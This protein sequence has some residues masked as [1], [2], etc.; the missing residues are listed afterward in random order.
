MSGHR[1]CGRGG[2][3][4]LLAITAGGCLSLNRLTDLS[5]KFAAQFTLRLPEFAPSCVFSVAVVVRS[6]WAEAKR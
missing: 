1:A 3:V 4:T 6:T 5:S 2:T